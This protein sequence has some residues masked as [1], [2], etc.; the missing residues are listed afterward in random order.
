MVVVRIEPV[1]KSGS[2][3]AIVLLTRLVG[4]GRRFL[5]FPV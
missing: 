1:Q 3:V 5:L 2:G 4:G